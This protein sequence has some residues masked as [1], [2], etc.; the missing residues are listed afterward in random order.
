MFGGQ[1]PPELPLV[2][3]PRLVSTAGQVL[4]DGSRDKEKAGN[5]EQ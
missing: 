4:D 3:N 1:L 5:K 2:W